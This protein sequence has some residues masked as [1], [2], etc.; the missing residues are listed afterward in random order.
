MLMQKTLSI[1]NWILNIFLVKMDLDKH[2][3]QDELFC[4]LRISS[5]EHV[6]KDGLSWTT[7]L[8]A[9]SCYLL[10]YTYVMTGIHKI[11]KVISRKH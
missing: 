2:L 5:L 4:I 7:S 11:P 8:V 1:R 6:I 10:N 3:K 9:T